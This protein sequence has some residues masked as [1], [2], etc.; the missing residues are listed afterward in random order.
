M[1]ITIEMPK[2]GEVETSVILSHWFKNAGDQ[3][4]V[5][6][7]VVQVKVD[8]YT[9]E[10][11]AFDW[12]TLSEIFVA[13]GQRLTAGEKLAV[14]TPWPYPAPKTI[15][16]LGSMAR[17][18]SSVYPQQKKLG[19]DG[20]LHFIGW[21]V[22]LIATWNIAFRTDSFL[23]DYSPW[24]YWPVG[25]VLLAVVLGITAFFLLYGIRKDPAFS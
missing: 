20:I 12:G 19:L 13:E 21:L 3:V 14:L 9:L 22:A 15:A 1:S 11:E 10:L 24:V 23:R 25:S 4:E 17:T 6:D 18:L 7:A 5:G 16:T 2:L 8:G